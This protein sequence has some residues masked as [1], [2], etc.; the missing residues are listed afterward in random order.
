MSLLD[1]IALIFGVL[2][3][4]LTIKQSIWC[5]PSA[6]ISVLA[7]F[8]AFYNQRLFGDMLLQIFYFLSGIYGWY[9][10]KKNKQV[11]FIVQ[12]INL[13]IIPSLLLITAVLNVILFFILNYFKGDKVILDSILTAF[14]LT[15]TYMM[16]KK[17][18][19]NWIAWVVIDFTYIIL[20]TSKSMWLFALL[21]FIFTLMAAY[22]FF[23]W[24]KLLKK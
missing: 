1:S 3:V 15:A 16:T 13:K 18:I 17:W 19:E 22:G 14:S 6:L 11:T 21:Y 2:G 10:W 9:F 8:V 4:L 20:Y 24:K 12:K 5:W 7:S 23:K